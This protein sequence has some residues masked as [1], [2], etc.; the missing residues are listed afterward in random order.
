MSGADM[1]TTGGLVALASSARGVWALMSVV[2]TTLGPLS[3]TKLLVDRFGEVLVSSDAATLLCSMDI[4]HSG[5]KLV[6][7]IARAQRVQSGDGVA[8]T[9]LITGSLLQ[10]VIEL[11]QRKYSPVAVVRALQQVEIELPS[12]AAAFFDPEQPSTSSLKPA[13]EREALH[14]RRTQLVKSSLSTKVNDIDAERLC[15]LILQSTVARPQRCLQV[16]A[17]ITFVCALAC[18]ALE[19]SRRF[20]GWRVQRRRHAA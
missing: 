7:E 2:Q 6:V 19:V 8:S 14:H 18:I 9:I 1:E 12:L 13:A 16:R 10:A 17:A 4:Q 11:V 20:C 3:R 5:A 15:A